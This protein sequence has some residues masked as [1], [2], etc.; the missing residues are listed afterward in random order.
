[1]F[2]VHAVPFPLPIPLL[3]SRLNTPQQYSVAEQMNR[4]PPDMARTLVQRQ[5]VRMAFWSEVIE[6]AT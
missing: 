6:T 3:Y 2:S 5:S 1:M 4:T